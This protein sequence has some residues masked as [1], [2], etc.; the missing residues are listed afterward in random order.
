MWP[1][2]M[3]CNWKG[4]GSMQE[5][6]LCQ[7]AWVGWC[8][9][10]R[11]RVHFPNKCIRWSPHTLTDR[12]STADHCWRFLNLQVTLAEDEFR[13]REAEVAYALSQ[14][15]VRDVWEERMPL[16][17]DAALALGCVAAVAPAVRSR[18]LSDG[19]DLTDLQ[20]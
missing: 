14:P 1:L 20:V 17:L 3:G 10:L 5:S 18:P 9:S 15:H 8:Q 6:S 16:A 13:R 11:P 12:F 2:F 7:S 19:F 4:Q